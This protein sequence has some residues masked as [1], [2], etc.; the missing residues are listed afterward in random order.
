MHDL[1]KEQ[2]YEHIPKE[3]LL[4]DLQENLDSLKKNFAELSN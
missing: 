1:M 4:K 3:E 2:N